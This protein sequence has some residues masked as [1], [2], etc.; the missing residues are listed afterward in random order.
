MKTRFFLNLSLL[1]CIEVLDIH[2]SLSGASVAGSASSSVSGQQALS[3]N[4]AVSYAYIRLAPN[5]PLEGDLYA[6]KV[7]NSGRVLLSS[8]NG[9]Y[10]E[11]STIGARWYQGQL[12]PLYTP[13]L[14]FFD[15]VLDT[16]GVGIANM[17]DSGDIIGYVSAFYSTYYGTFDEYGLYWA[18]GS[19]VGVRMSTPTGYLGGQPRNLSAVPQFIT[20]S[21]GV[22]GD[23][24][25]EGYPFG[26][27][28][29]DG[30][31]WNSPQSIPTREGSGYINTEL[32]EFEL[33]HNSVVAQSSGGK[34]IRYFS[35]I[36]RALEDYD[37]GT[38]LHYGSSYYKIEGWTVPSGD[39][40]NRYSPLAINDG[41]RFV[42]KYTA[43]GELAWGEPQGQ[44]STLEKGSVV[45][46]NNGK[47]ILTISAQS[48]P[49]L[50]R[51][52][53][54][55]TAGASSYKKFGLS[56]DDRMELSYPSSINDLGAITART[57][58][59]AD[60]D[61]VTLPQPGPWFP[62]LLIPAELAVDNNRDGTINLSGD[63]TTLPTSDLTSRAKP[64]R[65]WINDDVDAGGI[66]TADIPAQ[67]VSGNVAGTAT[68]ADYRTWSDGSGNDVGLV[69]G[70]RDLID[71]FP[72]FLDIK[73][74][75]TVLPPSTAVKYKIKQA[76]GALN[77]IYTNLTRATALDY[78]R[79]VLTSGFGPALTQSAQIATKY[80]I[81]PAGIDIFSGSSGSSAFFDAV[82]NHD[83][84][85]ILIDARATTA[86]PLTISIEKTDGTVIAEVSLNIKTG[87]VEQMFRHLNLHD[88]NLPGL[89]G[90][91]PG[92][93]AQ[94]EA[95][96]D[97]TGFPDSP[98]SNSRWLIFVH[99]FNVSGQASRG[100]NAEMFKRTYWSH[101]KARF[102]GVSW[103][104]NPDQVLDAVSD[105]HLA[106]RNAMATAPVLAQAINAL[107]GVASTKTM[108][109]HSLGCGVISSAIADHGMDIYR[110]CFVDAALARECFDGRDPNA[111]TVERDGM[112]PAAWKSY[113]PK[114]FAANWFSQF[115]DKR[116]LLTWKNRFT[117]TDNGQRDA[118]ISVYN[119]FSSTEDVLGETNEE[120][121]TSVVGQPDFPLLHG[122]FGWVFQEKGKGNR[123]SYVAGLTHLGSLYGGWGFNVND[124]LT[125][126]LPKWY[127][128]D[129]ARQLR[130][131]KTQLEIG[132]VT[133]SLLNGSR[134][135]PLFKSGW[136]R[137]DGANPA[138]ELIDSSPAMNDGP[139]WILSLYGASTGNTIA[140]DPLKRSQLL[141]EAIPSLTWCT[142]SHKTLSFGNDR[143]FNLP[144]LVDQINWPRGSP[145]N[146]DPE[147]RHSDMREIAYIYQSSV[148]DK[149]VTT[150][151]PSP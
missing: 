146:G 68:G 6:R 110:V 95:L 20:S 116:G 14:S 47:S 132:T 18:A 35:L 70:S 41:L 26:F 9:T 50:W 2:Q 150:L 122:T 137:Y 120:I 93:A 140:T 101:N 76:D 4:P 105:Y 38:Y 46:I 56:I 54:G 107:D 125:S 21:G 109:A 89:N 63:V 99:G 36:G 15:D 22:Y 75:L 144:S 45:G 49:L 8:T 67:G 113:D 34:L 141:A 115:T 31:L 87:P 27:W 71:Y 131:P 127:V 97:P 65:F 62:S 55:V 24:W 73:Q 147:W 72:V 74:L 119:F 124:P 135:N 145:S 133:T 94:P 121:P 118:S 61:G 78:Q 51:W 12:E 84:G 100:W 90:S 60:D 66:A 117:R 69:Q 7:T 43:S 48:E 64:F 143:N 25:Y 114:L 3:V 83:G 104:G 136:G 106:M 17:N 149:I 103:F 85:V 37:A 108:F 1:V 123:Q 19:S 130:R 142:G 96:G 16:C 81:T 138:Q 11:G 52:I 29:T 59:I 23:L 111:F 82:T 44:L 98:N 79:K 42:G 112:T 13:T 58:K 92:G 86:K 102:V 10:S 139:S 77:L 91:M 134:Y 32:D 129:P 57:R 126:N 128:P 80:R 40:V 151:T 30:L 28:L 88:R 148:F 39:S 33:L 5:D 53:L